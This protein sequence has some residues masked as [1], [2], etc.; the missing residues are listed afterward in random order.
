MTERG[1]TF[2]ELMVTVLALFLGLMLAGV[3]RGIQ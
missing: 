1:V 3:L 2:T